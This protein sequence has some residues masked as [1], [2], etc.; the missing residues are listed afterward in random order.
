VVKKIREHGRNSLKDN[1]LGQELTYHNDRTAEVLSR[2][3]EA[4]KDR[5]VRLGINEHSF[6][7]RDLVIT[8]TNLKRRKVLAVLPDDRQATLRQFLVK[9]PESI[10]RKIEEVFGDIKPAFIMVT[11]EELPETNIVIDRFHVVH[12][13]NR[14]VDEARRIEQE[15]TRKPIPKYLILKAEERLTDKQRQWLDHYL[16]LYPSLR[17]CYLTKEQLRGIYWAESKEK[18]GSFWSV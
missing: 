15:A 13:A 12:D 11:E 4:L 17:E 3:E 2:W 6:R 1:K 9:I 5:K 10:K 14:Q 8:V 7:G 18:P 16:T